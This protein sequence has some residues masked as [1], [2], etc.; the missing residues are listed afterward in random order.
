MVVGMHERVVTLDA[1]QQLDGAVGDH[2]IGVHVGGCA[3]AAL[4][5]VD[6][7]LVV[8]LPVDQL[9]AG[10]FDGLRHPG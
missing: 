9:V 2:L 6:D 7:E 4:N 3:R 10:A 1:A 5:R 8:Q